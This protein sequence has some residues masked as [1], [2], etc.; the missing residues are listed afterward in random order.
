MDAGSTGGDLVIVTTRSRLQQRTSFVPM[1]V[2]T[3]LI[4]RQLTRTEGLIRWASV[5]ADRTEFSTVT[6]WR[7][8]HVM[9]EFMRSQAHGRYLWRVS[10]WLS[11][12]W[13]MRWRPGSH[14]VG[15]WDGLELTAPDHADTAPVDPALN[16]RADLVLGRIPELRAAMGERAIASH[17]D[18]PTTARNRRRV[19]GSSGLLVR[20]PVR[21]W[22]RPAALRELRRLREDLS[23]EPTLF[24][25]TFGPAAPQAVL[26]LAVFTDA[27]RPA[28]LI[29]EGPVTDLVARRPGS[30]ALELL[31]ES[32]FG[33]WDGRRLRSELRRGVS[34][35][36]T[37]AATPPWRSPRG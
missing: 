4:R 15:A 16:E 22:R 30:A 27:A 11:S 37:T 8:T 35:S 36:A 14:A 9:Q 31:P 21:R 23:T 32:E 18:A 5:V 17:R 20:V 1:V 25:V 29:A 34:R 10:R 6:V 2:A 24:G 28:Q 19:T 26:L 12:F 3:A 13:L 33:H 7:N